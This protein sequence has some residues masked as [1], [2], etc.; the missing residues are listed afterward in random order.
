MV[1]YTVLATKKI[2]KSEKI[3]KSLNNFWGPCQVL[4]RRLHRST[5]I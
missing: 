2:K 4:N 5:Y 3:K 1:I